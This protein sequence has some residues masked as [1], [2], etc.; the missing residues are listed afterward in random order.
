M[1]E[2]TDQYTCWLYSYSFKSSEA[3]AKPFHPG[4]TGPAV[5]GSTVIFLSPFRIP[6]TPS[7]LTHCSLEFMLS[8]Y[9]CMYVYV[10]IDGEMGLCMGY[11]CVVV[12]DGRGKWARGPYKR[13]VYIMA[14]KNFDMKTLLELEC[15]SEYL[16][17]NSDIV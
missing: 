6:D 5:G 13:K 2:E 3:P 15:L 4:L 11:G 8:M 16:P 17:W 10:K 1:Y 7:V 12:D 9:V 14:E